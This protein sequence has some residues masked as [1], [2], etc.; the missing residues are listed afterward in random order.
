MSWTAILA[1]I[2]SALAAIGSL[3]DAVKGFL[4]FADRQEAKEAGRDEARV[5]AGEIRD[6]AETEA[7]KA[8]E[9]ARA[10]HV[11]NS[12][13]DSAFDNDFKRD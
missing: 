13:D 3:A 12:E 2:S 9:Q 5:D 11:S 6:A 10:E 7:D 4:G 1:A 8:R